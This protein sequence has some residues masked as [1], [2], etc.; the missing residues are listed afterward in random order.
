MSTAAPTFDED[1]Q[2]Q[3]TALFAW[4]RDVRHFRGDPLPDGT[5][6]DLLDIACRSPSVGNAQPWRFVHV[7]TPERRRAL[8]DH[9]D[10]CKDKAAQAY[11][12]E[13][14][15]LYD[16]LKL[17]GLREA[18]EVIAV[19]CD[20]QAATGHGLGRATMPETLC[21]STITAI[22][23]L[24]L[25]ARAR[26]IGMGW[27]SIVDPGAMHGL[28]EIPADWRFIALLCLGFAADENDTPE[29]V[30]HGWQDRLPASTTRFIR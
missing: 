5:L 25:A 12:T 23:T 29:L 7:F 28:L 4:R 27:V 1:F 17:H 20:E 19:F 26:G 8:A 24:W 15:V 2:D 13:R 9:V 22:H 10:G 3:L 11:D 16:G 21:W 30:R 6:D 14:R 18:P